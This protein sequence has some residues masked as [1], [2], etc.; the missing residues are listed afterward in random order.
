MNTKQV[1]EL[2]G[3]SRQNIRYYERAGLLHPKRE[4]GS[5]YRDYSP[6]DVNCLRMIKFL[7]MLDMPIEEVARVLKEEISLEDAVI[8]QRK[9][10]EQQQKLLQGAIEVCSQISRELPKEKNIRSF[11][12][13]EY[14]SRM[15][16]EQNKVGG[17][18]QF[19]DDY[20]KVVEAQSQKQFSWICPKW[21]LSEVELKEVLEE[22]IEEDWQWK[23]QD[24]KEYVIKED[25]VY[26]IQKKKIRNRKNGDCST[27]II[28]NMAH[29][30]QADDYQIP[31]RRKRWMC[32]MHMLSRDIVRHKWKTCLSVGI[33]ALAVCLINLYYGNILSLEKQYQNLPEAMPVEAVICNETGSKQGGIL[34]EDK[35][36]KMLQ[37]SK[38]VTEYQEQIELQGSLTAA[39]DKKQYRIQGANQ[40]AAITEYKEQIQWAKG[41]DEKRF[42]QEK[43]ACL[44]E[45]SFLK[46]Y[47]ISPG[48]EIEI[49]ID[50][51]KKSNLLNVQ[52]KE[53]QICPLKKVRVEI[54]GVYQGGTTD[55]QMF[56]STNAVRKWHQ[57]E[58][59]A[60]C[61]GSAAF[62]LKDPLS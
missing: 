50:Y 36:T 41:W 12:I 16:Y 6:E 1:E 18:A 27:L 13:Q 43:N 5:A 7:R 45:E 15:E 20:R 59:I 44:A 60:Y 21:P 48:D 35:L 24:G 40:L 29:P 17:F 52:Y 9:K 61:A 11:P 10:L 8:L 54:A 26:E 34:I 47:G 33:C 19:K 42:F 30:E 25:V 62:Q 56:V 14:L 22:V 58:K 51:Y 53:L 46:S 57:E 38:Y 3:I 37:D 49:D 39:G 2:T 23:K 31:G 4:A 28:G 55:S 32:G